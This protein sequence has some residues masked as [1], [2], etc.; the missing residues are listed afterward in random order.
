MTD[1]EALKLFDAELKKLNSYN[2]VLINFI[3][4]IFLFCSIPLMIIPAS[5]LSTVKSIILE[6]LLCATIMHLKLRLF[7][8][9]NEK[10]YSIYRIISFTGL[11]RKSYIKERTGYLL[12]YLCKLIP[13]TLMAQ[14]IGLKIASDCFTSSNLLYSFVYLI[15]IWVFLF[16][17]GYIMIFFSTKA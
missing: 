13:V 1:K 11:T 7:T 15:I 16:I 6:L 5:E 10:R 14:L 3:K 17:T 4:Y 9:Q 2:M 12:S 8:I